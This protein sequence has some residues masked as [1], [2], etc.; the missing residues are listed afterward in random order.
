MTSRQRVI[1]AINHQEP[2]RMPIDMGMHLSSGISA[3]AYWNL[4]EYLG[5]P[6][7][8]VEFVDGVQV[9]ARVEEDILQRFNCDCIF[10]R[11]KAE[12][13]QIWNPRGKYK[14]KVPEYYNPAL[15][16]KGEWVVSNPNG[17]MRMPKDGFFF[18]GDWLGMENVWEEPFF[19]EMALEAE[20]LYKETDYF[21]AFMGFY[22]FF[23]P[24][25]DYFC[26]MVTDPDTLREKNAAILK[27]E[28]ERAALFIKKMGKYV[29]AVCMS[30]DLGAQTGPMVKPDVFEYVTAPFL[31][32]FCKFM[33]TNSDSK[34][35]LHCC[36]AIEPL[37][38]VLIDCGIDILNPVQISA[39]GMDPETLKRKYG[40]D[41]TFW[42]GGVNTQQVLNFGNTGEV[43]DNVKHLTDIFKPGGGFVF[44]PVH[45]IMGDIV[46]ENIV[47]AYDAAYHNSKY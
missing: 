15:N 32:E 45:N 24:S 10:L 7:D 44:C 46:P 19:S 20:R 11:P 31:K 8:S 34:V 6:I 43:A 5:L 4:R 1:A 26:D 42:G 39:E 37:L 33:H 47:A 27:S 14:F 35:F 25:I 30:G 28:L 29:G 41:I 21:T 9:L 22:P 38:P 40:K 18:D 13:F 17:S 2:D 23:D 16:D 3:F 12:K 36:G